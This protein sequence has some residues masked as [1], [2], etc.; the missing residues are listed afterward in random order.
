M[1][2]IIKECVSLLIEPEEENDLLND[3]VNVEE[4]DNSQFLVQS[5]HYYLNHLIHPFSFFSFLLFIFVF[6]FVFVFVFD[7]QY[8]YINYIF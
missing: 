4:E 6:V 1:C 7:L 5:D 3:W 2:V 8:L